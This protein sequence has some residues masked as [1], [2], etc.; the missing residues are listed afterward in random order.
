M[1][2][3]SENRVFRRPSSSVYYCQRKPKNRKNGGGLGTRLLYPCC[4]HTREV[5][6]TPRIPIASS[7]CVSSRTASY[8]NSSANGA[9]LQTEHVHRQHTLNCSALWRSLSAALSS[10][11]SSPRMSLL[12]EGA[13]NHQS[14]NFRLSLVPRL[15]S[16]LILRYIVMFNFFTF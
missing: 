6:S 2:K 14:S 9:T 5:I 13:G 7:P 1:R 3:G 16:P 15:L 4:A 11:T 12:Q 10:H 8:L